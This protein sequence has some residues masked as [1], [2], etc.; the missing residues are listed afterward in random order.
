MAIMSMLATSKTLIDLS[1][2][3]LTSSV[4]SL[5]TA[6]PAV[7]ASHSLRFRHRKVDSDSGKHND[8]HDTRRAGKHAFDGPDMR[9]EVLGK[10]DALRPLLPELDMAIR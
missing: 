3:M 7:K 1:L 6:K 4:P 9:P 8:M 10:L 2:L 5:L